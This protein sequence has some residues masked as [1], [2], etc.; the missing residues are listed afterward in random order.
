MC[1]PENDFSDQKDWY[2]YYRNIEQKGK[3]FMDD[4]YYD[5]LVHI[6]MEREQQVENARYLV[7]KIKKYF[8]HTKS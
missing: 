6:R 8:T 1:L 4:N 5:E 7:N 3:C 2:S